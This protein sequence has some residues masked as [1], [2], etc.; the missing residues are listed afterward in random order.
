MISVIES[1]SAPPTWLAGLWF[2]IAYEVQT[3]FE[4]IRF[5]LM[6]E[7]KPSLREFVENSAKITAFPLRCPKK[8]SCGCFVSA[9]KE[10][11]IRGR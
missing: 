1:L 5:Q 9:D 10:L 2:N 3:E 7:G 6:R 8:K 4:Y 11:S